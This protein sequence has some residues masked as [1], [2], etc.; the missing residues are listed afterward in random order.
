MQEKCFSSRFKATD[1]KWDKMCGKQLFK[2]CELRTWYI[3][4]SKRWERQLAEFLKRLRV[5]GI[6]MGFAIREPRR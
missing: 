4:Y 1:A 5:L 2:S 6:N 3:I